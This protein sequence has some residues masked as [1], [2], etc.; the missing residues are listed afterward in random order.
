M[1]KVVEV[2]G[3]V[4][5]FEGGRVH[6]VDGIDLATEEGEYLS[7]SAPRDAQDHP[8]AHHRRARAAERGGGPHRRAGRQR[9]APAGPQDRHGL[10]RATPC[11]RHNVL[12]NIVFPLKAEGMDKDEQVRKASLGARELLGIDQLLD[13]RPRQLSGGERQRVALAS[14]AG[15]RPARVPARRTAL[16]PGRQAA[17]Q[18]PR[19]AQAVPGAGRNDD[20]RLPSPRP[21]RGHGPGRPDRGHGPG[22]GAALARWSRSTTTRPTPGHPLPAAPCR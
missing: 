19:R 4:K 1:T 11:T 13:R 12:Q 22:P 8:A 3:L 7:S 5:Q 16:Q 17:D 9:P 20:H 21:G 6:A 2:R 14:G 10:P 15:P 18:R